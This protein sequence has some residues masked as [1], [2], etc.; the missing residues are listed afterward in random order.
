MCMYSLLALMNM[1]KLMH[2][3][4][5]C[6][7]L[8]ILSLWQ[9]LLSSLFTWCVHTL[10]ANLMIRD[11]FLP[12]KLFFLFI[13]MWCL[14]Q[15]SLQKK[16]VANP[17][18][19]ANNSAQLHV[20]CTSTSTCTVCTNIHASLPPMCACSHLLTSSNLPIL[21]QVLLECDLRPGG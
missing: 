4:K 11:L 1:I 5:M 7:M 13:H 12:S 19:S 15:R 16:D 8:E 6:F 10:L 3:F 21:M 2:T 17:F 20:Q 18:H 14:P 9:L